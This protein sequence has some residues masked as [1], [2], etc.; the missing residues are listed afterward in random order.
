MVRLPLKIAFALTLVSV[1]LLF[2]FLTLGPAE[3][4]AQQN[5]ESY[6][7]W[8]KFDRCLDWGAFSMSKPSYARPHS[9]GFANIGAACGTSGCF[10][11]IRFP[12]KTKCRVPI[13][14]DRKAI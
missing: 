6:R 14:T 9:N 2:D 4:W 1:A 12:P 5:S 10:G 13:S 11:V 3:R 8:V 7:T